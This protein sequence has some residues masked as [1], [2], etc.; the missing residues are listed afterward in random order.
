MPDPQPNRPDNPVEC[1][2]LALFV[3][4][5]TRGHRFEHDIRHQFG[6]GKTLWSQYR[7]GSQ[8][9]ELDLLNRLIRQ[10]RP[11]DEQV[12]LLTQ[13]KTLHRDAVD[14]RAGR[15]LIM[16]APDP[17]PFPIVLEAAAEVVCGTSD[18]VFVRD[19]ANERRTGE[20][21]KSDLSWDMV[22]PPDM[23]DRFPVSK[24]VEGCFVTTEDG[25]HFTQ[26]HGL[27]SPWPRYTRIYPVGTTCVAT[28]RETNGTGVYLAL[29]QGGR[30]RLHERDL[31]QDV[32]MV[33]AQ[34]EVKITG[35]FPQQ[36]KIEVARLH[37]PQ[38]DTDWSQFPRYGERVTGRIQYQHPQRR[39]MLLDLEEYPNMPLGTMALL[40]H[41]AM[42]PALKR[43]FESDQLSAGDRLFLKVTA[44]RLSVHRPGMINLNVTEVEASDD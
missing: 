12:D 20:F 18:S 19:T 27:M 16:S 5:V 4:R 26:R 31:S 1:Q 30:S 38:D 13:A 6:I 36:R 10:L 23:L 37:P 17:G 22:V 41:S 24:Q 25:T 21:R 35:V 2:N 3:K 29:A 14:A 44:I 15:G 8:D 7:N 28:V 42:N 34:V 39:Y 11:V 40:H 43:S 33:G 32:L 9:I